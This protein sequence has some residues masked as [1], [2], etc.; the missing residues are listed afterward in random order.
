MNN[1]RSLA[2]W[3]DAIDSIPAIAKL[4]SAARHPSQTLEFIIVTLPGLE[5]HV[6]TNDLNRR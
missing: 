2:A 1:A 3:A 5:G 4:A 6:S